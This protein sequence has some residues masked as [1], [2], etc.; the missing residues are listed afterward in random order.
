MSTSLSLLFLLFQVLESS[1]KHLQKSSVKRK[2][3]RSISE[4]LIHSH[5]SPN[6]TTKVVMTNRR[7]FQLKAKGTPREAYKL[8]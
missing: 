4:V 5:N 3:Y 1:N 6:T 2:D 7:E 8:I